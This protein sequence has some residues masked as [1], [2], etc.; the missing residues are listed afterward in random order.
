[1]YVLN[2]RQELRRP[3]T[4]NA[5]YYVVRQV[6]SNPDCKTTLFNSPTHKYAPSRRDGWILPEVNSLPRIPL[7]RVQVGFAAW[8]HESPLFK[9]LTLAHQTQKHASR[10][11]TDGIIS[12][13]IFGLQINGFTLPFGKRLLDTLYFHGYASKTA[14]TLSI[15]N[16]AFY[17][18]TNRFLHHQQGQV[19]CNQSDHLVPDT[20]PRICVSVGA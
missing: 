18:T 5:N 15:S 2:T 6:Q 17:K 3:R 11:R 13:Q 8:T 12:R 4:F 19:V 14:L 1:M 20:P 16:Y 10:S 9:L 7:L